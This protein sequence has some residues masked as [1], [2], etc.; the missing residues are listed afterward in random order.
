MNAIFSKA[1]PFC[2]IASMINS[3]SA[4]SEKCEK[5]TAGILKAVDRAVSFQQPIGIAS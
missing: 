5:V 4:L 3:L 1:S 2:M